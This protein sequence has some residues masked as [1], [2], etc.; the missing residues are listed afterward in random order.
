[1]TPPPLL[2]LYHHIGEGSL[3]ASPHHRSRRSHRRRRSTSRSQKES[4]S[5]LK[6]V[7]CWTRALWMYLRG[8]AAHPWFFASWNPVEAYSLT[9]SAATLPPTYAPHNTTSFSGRR[10]RMGAQTA[11]AAASFHVPIRTSRVGP[12]SSRCALSSCSLLVWLEPIIL[13]LDCF[14]PLKIILLILT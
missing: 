2:H 9:T 14:V 1:M 3:S 5:T 10:G 13:E 6:A 12:Q 11:R 4:Y 8:R 7:S